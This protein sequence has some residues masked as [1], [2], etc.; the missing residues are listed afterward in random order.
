M[1]KSKRPMSFSKKLAIIGFAIYLTFILLSQIPNLA[2]TGVRQAMDD[3]Y[4]YDL[5]FKTDGEQSHYYV[6]RLNT[7]LPGEITLTYWTDSHTLKVETKNIKKLTIDA[8]SIYKDE[9]MKVFK[10]DP[11]VDADYYKDYF[12]DKDRFLVNVIASNDITELRF[13]DAPEPTLVYVNNIEWWRTN[14]NY[15]FEDP[16]IVLTNVSMG[17]TTVRLFFKPVLEP[18]A[19]FEFKGDFTY[20]QNSIQ[21]GY[22]DKNINF[23]ASASNDN[24]DSGFIDRWDWTFGDGVT[25]SGETTMHKY[26]ATGTYE[27]TLKVTDNHK[28]VN[29]ITKSIIIIEETN[30]QDNDGIDDAWEIQYFGEITRWGARDDPDGDNLEN[31]DEFNALTYP[32]DPDSD[33][34]DL[35]DGWELDWGFDPL[36]NLGDDGKYGDPDLDNHSNFDEFEHDTDPTDGTSFYTEPKDPKDSDDGSFGLIAIIVV[37]I[38][39]VLLLS[40]IMIYGRRRRSEEPEPDIE[41]TKLELDEELD[42]PEAGMAEDFEIE[43]DAGEL[44]EEFEPDEG[45]EDW[46]S[47][48]TGEVRAPGAEVG[49]L[50]VEALRPEVKT[51]EEAERMELM[52]LGVV[53]PCDVCQGMM[54][55]GKQVFQC[56]CGMISHAGCISELAMCPQCGRD[57]DYEQLGVSQEE[58]AAL[59][60][61]PEFE[62]EIK[63]KKPMI[64]REIKREITEQAA[65][66]AS[67]FTFI[68][69]RTTDRE[70]R[71]YMKGYLKSKQIG[72]ESVDETVSDV[73]IYLSLDVA[74]KIMDH[75]YDHGRQ[76]EV[77]G[78]IMG[79]TYKDKNTNK[80]YSIARDVATS[81]LDASE[82][83]VRFENFDKLFNQLESLDYEY[84]ILG[85]YH[86]HPDYSS[87][88]SPTDIDTQRRMFKQPYQ[89]A[90][91]V[92]PIR[93]DMKTFTHDRLRKKKAKELPYAIFNY[94]RFK[95]GGPLLPSMEKAAA[96]EPSKPMI[97]REVKQEMEQLEHAPGRAYMT[98][99]PGVTPDRNIKQ[100]LEGYFDRGKTGRPTVSDGLGIIVTNFITIDAAKKMLDHCFKYK[101][102]QEVMGLIIGKTYKYENKIISIGRDIAS[103]ELNATAVNVRFE[104]FEKLFKQLDNID[105]E[106]QIVGWYHS[107]PGHSC[108]MSPTDV[109]TQK[110]MFTHAHQ[111]ALVIDPINYDIKGFTLDQSSKNKVKARAF[112]IIE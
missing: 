50:E 38:I 81:D 40:Y 43:G 110:R 13:K 90:M 87:F 51:F 103:S 5:V 21:Y 64:K 36:N 28:L 85:W 72:S 95:K 12:Y 108:F 104:S 23:D 14:T 68:P 111:Y 49:A 67:Y 26:T 89:Y 11:A 57:I 58:L 93:F 27:V 76:K 109:D 45:Y 9:S 46:E 94:K 34:D 17:S 32:D 77:M 107:H 99:I 88:M 52:E 37:I 91:V 61:P 65:P 102:K 83:D 2:Q 105:Y 16:D 56:S 86:S 82:V 4:D 73:H 101:D 98:Y 75:C 60:P 100:Y 15:E 20:V 63:P 35:P 96:G 39:I 33:D 24:S 80:T 44:E 30:D 70:I 18:T 7:N 41:H 106:Y 59:G 97:R 84:Q 66:E 54:P 10:R 112:A 31:L 53:S 79:Q 22:L 48:T 42:E 8:D 78:L 3:R 62:P 55:L 19:S 29:S 71:E 6:E 69:K 74:K 1:K 25:D 47:K 92:D